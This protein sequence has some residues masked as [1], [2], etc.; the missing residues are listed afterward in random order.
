KA[1]LVFG[2]WICFSYVTAQNRDVAYLVFIDYVKIFVMFVVAALAVRTLRQVWWIYLL[3]TGALIYIAYELNYLYFTAGRL[4]IYHN[5]YGVR[6]TNGAGLMVAMAGPLA[7]HGWEASTK[8]WRW[9]LLAG[10]PLLIH[11]VLMSYS[12]GVM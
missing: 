11:A 10:V 5:G 12:R 9:L 2:A 1:Y 8:K 7:V 6:E 3:S 4:D